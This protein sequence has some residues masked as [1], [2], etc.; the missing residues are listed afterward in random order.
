MDVLLEL[1]RIEFSA[2][3]RLHRDRHGSLLRGSLSNTIPVDEVE[4]RGFRTNQSLRARETQPNNGLVGMLGEQLKVQIEEERQKEEERRKWVA[5][6][7][8]K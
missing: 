3:R 8:G 6:N 5:E 1:Q 7:G 2:A 4:V